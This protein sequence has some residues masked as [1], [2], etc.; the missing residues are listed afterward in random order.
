MSAAL[1][2]VGCDQYQG[3]PAGWLKFAG[4]LTKVSLQ[5]GS[6][7]AAEEWSQSWKHYRQIA[8]PMSTCIAVSLNTRAFRNPSATTAPPSSRSL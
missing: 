6:R 5:V 8:K 1:V 3:T 4:L 2:W 7:Q